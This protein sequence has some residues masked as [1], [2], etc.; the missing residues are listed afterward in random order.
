MTVPA[1]FR[2]RIWLALPASFLV[3]AATAAARQILAPDG[4]AAAESWLWSFLR[5]IEQTAAYSAVLL[6]IAACG[7]LYRAWMFTARAAPAKRRSF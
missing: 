3:Y 1:P 4:S 5:A 2:S 6:V 7:V